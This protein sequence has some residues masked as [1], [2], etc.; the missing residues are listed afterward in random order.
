MYTINIPVFCH[1]PN[2][3]LNELRLPP[4]KDFELDPR[5]DDILKLKISLGTKPNLDGYNWYNHM[6][7]DTELSKFPD[8][9]QG[10]K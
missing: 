8:V 5:N 4:K 9:Q 6:K 2:M 7:N 1:N 3:A 10:W